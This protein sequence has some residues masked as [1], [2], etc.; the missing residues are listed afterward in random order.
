[1]LMYTIKKAPLHDTSDFLINVLLNCLNVFD[2]FV[3]LAPKWLILFFGAQL[4]AFVY[5]LHNYRTITSCAKVCNEFS[6]KLKFGA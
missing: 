6:A 4:Q 1:M 2:H 3:G 5:L